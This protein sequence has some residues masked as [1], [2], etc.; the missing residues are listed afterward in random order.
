M[1]KYSL[2]KVYD[3]GHI[4]RNNT[5][6][7]TKTHFLIILTL[8]IMYLVLTHKRAL[9]IVNVQVAWYVDQECTGCD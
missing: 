3:I 1:G 8:Y 5:L 2:G 9:F 7:F 6:F 4:E